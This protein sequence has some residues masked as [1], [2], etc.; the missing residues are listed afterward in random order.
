MRTSCLA[1][2]KLL[3]S[4]QIGDGGYRYVQ[5]MSALPPEADIETGPVISSTHQLRQLRHL[6]RDATGLIFREQLERIGT[7]KQKFATG[8]VNP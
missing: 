4:S 2:E 7:W 6:G 8:A 5:P 3:T 1:G